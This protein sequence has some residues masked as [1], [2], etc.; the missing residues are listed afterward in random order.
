MYQNPEFY[1]R[2]LGTSSVRHESSFVRSA[3]PRTDSPNEPSDPLRLG[4]SVLPPHGPALSFGVC[5]PSLAKANFLILSASI[6]EP[7]TFCHGNLHILS[8]KFTHFC[9]GNLHSLIC[10]LSFRCA[11]HTSHE[12]RSNQWIDFLTSNQCRINSTPSL[13]LSHILSHPISNLIP[14]SIPNSQPRLPYQS[15]QYIFSPNLTNPP[16]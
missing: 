7:T 15:H 9:H 1:K 2:V 11:S 3:S 12:L 4:E 14:Y 16:P 10:C 5:S 13:P 8:R 6:T